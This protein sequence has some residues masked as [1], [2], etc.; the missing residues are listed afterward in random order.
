[1][2][3]QVIQR[4]N[5]LAS[6]QTKVGAACFSSSSDEDGSVESKRSFAGPPMSQKHFTPSDEE[7]GE[8]GALKDDG[9]CDSDVVI[10]AAGGTE[11]H[12]QAMMGNKSMTT[13]ETHRALHH[14]GINLE[15]MT[16]LGIH[17][18]QE[19]SQ[20]ALCS[21]DAMKPHPV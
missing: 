18:E 17:L 4:C 16:E 13:E 8:D 3:E 11:R 7:I 2:D 6:K 15:E 20:N 14:K 9:L 1:L 21:G 5:L 10:E 12:V 19:T